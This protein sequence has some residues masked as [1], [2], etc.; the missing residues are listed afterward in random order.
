LRKFLI[1]AAALVIAGPAAA[2]QA[3]GTAVDEEIVRNLPSQ[4]EFDRMGESMSRL[5]GA[6]LN[7][8]VGPIVEAVDPGR[9]LSRAERERTLGEMAT[10]DDPYFEQR[11]RGSVGAVTANMGTMVRQLAVA[12]PALRRALE[13]VQR[14]VAAATRDIPLA[15]TE[16][17]PAEEYSP[18]DQD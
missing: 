16:T 11:M 12:T 8:Q 10:R 18:I 7:I 2:Q 13:Q 3:A 1:T 4:E 17:R 14:D 15:R 9:R 6:L 5:V